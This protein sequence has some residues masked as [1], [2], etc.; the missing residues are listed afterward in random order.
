MKFSTANDS[1]SGVSYILKAGMQLN[2]NISL[3]KF[4]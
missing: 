2:G 1:S 4:G 3:E